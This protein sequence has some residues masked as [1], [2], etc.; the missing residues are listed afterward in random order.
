M[1]NEIS[2]L[3]MPDRDPIVDNRA[4]VS[5]PWSEFFRLMRDLLSPL[6]SEKIFD[7]KNNIGLE[8]A[9]NNVPINID[10]LVF[11]SGTV[12]HAIVDYVIQ[13]LTVDPGTPVTINTEL[14]QAGCFHLVFK[15][16]SKVWSL[17]QIGTPGPDA[18]G[19]TLSVTTAGQVQ[20]KSTNI[21][22]TPSISRI[23]YRARTLAG[24]HAN[25]SKAGSR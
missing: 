6:G 11:D 9:P 3:K 21:S 24:K 8:A 14:S 23:I 2:L 17:V 19:V 7:I 16:G 5:R 20:Y 25:Y 15:P 4:M 10:G 13:R 18:S 1:P 12:S 22:G